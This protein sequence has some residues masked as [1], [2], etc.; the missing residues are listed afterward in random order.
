[1]FSKNVSQMRSYLTIL[2]PEKGNLS[3]KIVFSILAKKKPLGVLGGK[4]V[5][6]PPPSPDLCISETVRWKCDHCLLVSGEFSDLEV[7]FYLKR[8]LIY[9]IIQ[10][11]IPATLTVLLSWVNFYVNRHSVPARSVTNLH[12]CFDLIL[13]TQQTNCSIV[14]S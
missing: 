14:S 12:Q 4:S 9:F 5:L 8:D 2:S 6:R 1:M 10:T 13:V 3:K 11:Y 7:I